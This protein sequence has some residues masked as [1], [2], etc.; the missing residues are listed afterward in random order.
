MKTSVCDVFSTFHCEQ[1]D[2]EFYSVSLYYLIW[3]NTFPTFKVHTLVHLY[4]Y[5]YIKP[6]LVK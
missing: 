6:F 3:R 4:L 2:T 1:I 5:L